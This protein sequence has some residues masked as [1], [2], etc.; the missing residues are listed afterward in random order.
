MEATREALEGFYPKTRLF[1][2]HRKGKNKAMDVVCDPVNKRIWYEVSVSHQWVYTGPE[3][4]EAI[5]LFNAL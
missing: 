1:G 2:E 4:D 3:L 5:S